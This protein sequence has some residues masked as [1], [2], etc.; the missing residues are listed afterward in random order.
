[1]ANYTFPSESGA[2][3]ISNKTTGPETCL[4][5]KG[6][7]RVIGVQDPHRRRE[8]QIWWVEAIPNYENDKEGP[9]YSISHLTSYGNFSLQSQKWDYSEKANIYPSNGMQWQKWLIKRASEDKEGESYKIISVF[10]GAALAISSSGNPVGSNACMSEFSSNN[11]QQCWEF[12]IPVV[13]I[14]P[15]WV[16]IRNCCAT[17]E[18]LQQEYITSPPFLAPEWRFM[19]ENED[20][21]SPQN[22]WCIK[23]RLTD[24]YLSHSR[25]IYKTPNPIDIIAGEV[26]VSLFDEPQGNYGRDSQ[27]W[28]LQVHRDASWSIVNKLSGLALAKVE[29]PGGEEVGVKRN[30][31]GESDSK[32]RDFIISTDRVN[33]DMPR[34][35]IDTVTAG[36]S[37]LK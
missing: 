27:L 14:P 8:K 21:D 5:I 36:E 16:Q 37:D 22:Y 23:N 1:M 24:G 19:M 17:R 31:D 26:S 34:L 4:E 15:G 12:S 29:S 2:Y 13:G 9:I 35:M 32:R 28:K 6:M 10:D 25:E 7:S 20:E 3:L 33:T 18:F 11:P 30:S